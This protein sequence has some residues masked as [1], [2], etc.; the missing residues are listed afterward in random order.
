MKTLFFITGMIG[1]CMVMSDG[2]L[3]PTLNFAGCF[4]MLASIVLY[5][6]FDKEDK[7]TSFI[8]RDVHSK[9]WLKQEE[10]KA[11]TFNTY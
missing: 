2:Y 9:D 8:G 11:N 7:P 6:V 1:L 10:L 4:V 5:G 3:F